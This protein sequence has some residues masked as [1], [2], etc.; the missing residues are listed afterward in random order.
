MLVVVSDAALPDESSAPQS[1]RCHWV[2]PQTLEIRD[3]ARVPNYAYRVNDTPSIPMPSS[4]ATYQWNPTFSIDS[5]GHVHGNSKAVSSII[6]VSDN[7]C[8]PA[9]TA[10]IVYSD[11]FVPQREFTI[12]IGA[13]RVADEL[14][15]GSTDWRT[16][17]ASASLESPFGVRGA[18]LALDA[19]SIDYL[20]PANL[21]VGA[22]CPIAGDPGCVVSSSGSQRYRTGFT[23]RDTTFELRAGASLLP[24]GPAID[25]G[26]LY[27]LSNSGRPNL[28]GVG[29]GFEVP[30]N[31][32]QMFAAYGSVSYYPTLAGSGVAYSALRYRAGF[33]LS[34]FSGLHWLN[35]LDVAFLGDR[36]IATGSTPST[37]QLQAVTVSLGR[38]F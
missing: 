16:Y 12:G 34:A 7:V 19:R 36:R 13:S 30:P 11:G 15:P 8:A 2:A 32:D 23:V 17:A 10:V 29:F 3:G 18:L 21:S 24:H 5:G 27:G 31:L 33:T 9:D 26:Y 6:T 20:H 1:L 38:R 22:A 28:G 25:V 37:A 35:Y 14:D 4:T